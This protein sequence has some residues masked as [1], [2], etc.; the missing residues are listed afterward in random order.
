MGAESF[1]GAVNVYHGEIMAFTADRLNTL[2]VLK[3]V[4]HIVLTRVYR[5]SLAFTS[6]VCL[7][8]HF[9]FLS[10][11]LSLCCSQYS[12]LT[13]ELLNNVAFASKSKS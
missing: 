2:A 5:D 7:K 9:L 10:R 1:E 13:S 6:L 4:G 12:Q 3:K 11:N 8:K